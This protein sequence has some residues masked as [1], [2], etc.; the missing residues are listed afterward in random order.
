MIRRAEEQGAIQC[1]RFRT[2]TEEKKQWNKMGLK[3]SFDQFISIY[4]AGILYVFSGE[5][6]IFKYETAEWS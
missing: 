6:P 3:P 5:G 4:I 2:H 1:V